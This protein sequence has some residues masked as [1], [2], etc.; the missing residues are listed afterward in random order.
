MRGYGADLWPESGNLPYSIAHH[1]MPKPFFSIVIPTKNRGFL[2]KHPL[3]SL[4]RQ[5]FK[6]FEA[7][8]IDNDDGDETR[9]TFD[10][11]NDP[12]FRYVRTGNLSMPDNWEEACRQARG[13]YVLF[14]EDKQA[15]HIRALE[16]IHRAVEADRPDSVR[17]SSEAF[18]ELASPK[19]IWRTPG[20]G[21]VTTHSSDDILRC[22]TTRPRKEYARL[23]PIAHLSGVHRRAID[24]IRQTPVGR[25]CPPVSP[26]YTFAFLQL[27][28]VD[29]VCIINSP[30][31]VYVSKQHSNGRNMQ[32]KLAP[33]K[34]FTKELGGHNE[35]YFDHV[36]VK[37]FT[38]PGIIYNDYEK[39]R[40][41]VGGRLERHSI[42]PVS[43]FLECHGAIRY[44]EE[45]GVPMTE[46]LAEWRRAFEEQ[47]EELKA[48]IVKQLSADRATLRRAIRKVGKRL[49]IKYLENKCKSFFRS[50]IQH[51]PEW[52]FESAM[53]YIEWADKECP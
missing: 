32:L 24:R 47:P 19:R 6:D 26:D 2:V 20:D 42:D 49:G 27:A 38:I 15:L 23:L 7:V 35:I 48:E 16:R 39:L 41:L 40:K 8:L 37:A 33:G 5:S 22:F 3:Q 34:Q 4:L 28:V 31:V 1:D 53:D 25:V 45:E 9:K 43:Y 52:R 12:R 17:W 11:F 46:E 21:S 18:N 51:N 29:E 36:P 10:S 44:A 50:Q 13:E 30:L 14:L